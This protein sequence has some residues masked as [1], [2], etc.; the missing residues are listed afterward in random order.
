[1][2]G[3]LL[4][5][6][7][8][9]LLNEKGTLP[10]AISSKILRASTALSASHIINKSD[11]DNIYATS[12]IHADLKKLHYLLTEA[13]L[14]KRNKLVNVPD[15]M[16]EVAEGGLINWVPKRT[17][18]VIV[19]DMVDGSRNGNEVDD[20]VGNVEVLLHA[21]IYNLRIKARALGS[22][23]RFTIGNH[24]WHTVIKPYD[25]KE[26]N[27]F[28]SYVHKQAKNFFGKQQSAKDVYTNRRDWLLPFY[29]CCPY[30][31]L[32]VDSELAFIHGGLHLTNG[33]YAIEDIAEFQNNINSSKN[34][35]LAI[36]GDCKRSY[37][38]AEWGPLWT[39]FYAEKP[40][41]TVCA[42]IEDSKDYKMIVVG[43]CQTDPGNFIHYD[44]ILQE[45]EYN[46]CKCGGLVLLGCRDNVK[47]P[48]LAFVDIGMSCCFRGDREWF[49]ETGRRAEFLHLQHDSK[50][51]VAN[52]WY[53]VVKREVLSG[54]STAESTIVAWSDAA[55]AS[56]A[57]GGFRRSR[58]GR[59][60][61]SSSGGS[62]SSRKKR[63][64]V[65]RTRRR[66]SHLQ[67]F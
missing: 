49:S 11:Y 40:A 17:L 55:T 61:R 14:I 50:K 2:K 16:A 4:T 56:A 8:I 51:S 3:L 21:Y 19:G 18:F 6:A 37:L 22:E 20:A 30:L 46:A 10:T 41:A 25:V 64:K 63:T 13:G 39:R 1:M 12:D 54:L 60:G 67:H 66:N 35:D 53:N 34:F 65:K 42:A 9:K 59:S 7:D 52:R 5:A 33:A 38:S 31:F 58:S 24:D 47:A 26:D 28:T 32:N 62:S 48:R 44:E 15:I 23:I 36:T 27:L 29:N 45:P 57:A 43:H